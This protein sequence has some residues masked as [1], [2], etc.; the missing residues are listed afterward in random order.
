M[1]D[2]R[3]VVSTTSPPLLSYV[4]A[5]F[6]YLRSSSVLRLVAILAMLSWYPL[7]SS[8]WNAASDPD[9]WWQIRTGEWISQHHQ[10]P[11][12]DPFSITGIGK[13]WVAYSWS[14]G[15]L[16][17]AVAKTWDLVGIAGFSILSW[18]VLTALLFWVVSYVGR[19]F[20]IAV[21]LCF[22][23]SMVL[24]RVVAPRAGNFTILFFLITLRLLLTY[25][26]E[27]RAW[28]LFLL[29]P[30]FVLWANIHL[31]FLYGLILIGAFALEPFLNRI[32]LRK[33]WSWR[34]VAPVWIVLGVCTSATL[35][36]P[37]GTGPWRVIWEFLHQP[38]QYRY[39]TELHPMAFNLKVHYIVL[40]LCVA[41]AVCL[42]RE[43]KIQPIWTLLFAWAAVQGFHMERD[44][45]VLTVVSI[46]II[47][48]HV[49]STSMPSSQS[50]RWMKL[51]AF[52]SVLCVLI[53]S[54][55][56]APNNKELTGRLALQ[57][58]V[59]AVAYIHEHKLQG[60]I[61]NNF[62]WGGFL[63][64]SLP[65]FPVAI[66]GRT[67]VHNMVEIGRSLSTWD[68]TG[69]WREDP[70]LQKANLVIGSPKF[71]LTH[72]LLLDP[73][74]KLVFEDGFSIVYQRVRPA[75]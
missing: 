63:I 5:V 54:F 11:H 29:P 36:N 49:S 4:R 59:G 24:E 74:F 48:Q 64:Y 25:Q 56:A 27:K 33:P 72:A 31:Q 15:V 68:I 22:C 13:P 18:T 14:F 28:L 1:E 9:V 61:F 38:E 51:A 40:I 20:W 65:E 19:N 69:K 60:P 62:D 71:A 57:M 16:I 73:E 7:T 42:G 50:P 66:D 2:V 46:M 45:W 10:L 70:L 58:P 34:A 67:N 52:A 23:G 6:S 55:K 30:L 41:A 21:A 35:L 8:N 39:V 37:Y 75:Q 43:R 47:A 44:I 53:Y 12:T 32:F 3:D 26:R 17:H